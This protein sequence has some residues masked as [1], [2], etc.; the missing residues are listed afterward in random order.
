MNG[1]LLDTHIWFWYLVGSERLPRRVR[2]RID[3]EITSCW[4]SPISFWELGMLAHRKRVAIEGDF[5]A[6]VDRSRVKMPLREAAMNFEVAMASHEVALPHRDPADHF[7]AATALIYE[8]TLATVD[9]R[10]TEASWLPT[11][12]S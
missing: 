7:L 11:F 2:E 5:R 12:P 6:W 1:L 3:S 10:L 4:L 9:Q 8:L